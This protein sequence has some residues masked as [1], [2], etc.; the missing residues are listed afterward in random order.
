MKNAIKGITLLMGMVL[1]LTGC[2]AAATE[3]K[4]SGKIL[5]DGSSTVAPLT[6]AIIETFQ[7]K[8]SSIEITMGI[9]G[10]GGGFKKFVKGETQISNASRPMKKEEQETAKTNGIEYIELEIAKDAIAVV[11]NPAN[12]WAGELT[13]E[14]LKQIWMKDSTI[15]KWSDLDA[16]WPAE[17]IKLYGPGQDSGTFDY[18]K[19]VILGSDGEIRTDYTASEDDNVLVTGVA[20]D[21]NALGFFGYLYFEEN[22]TKLSAVA[23]NGVLPSVETVNDGTYKPLSR[24]IFIYVNKEAYNTDEAVKLFVDFYLDTIGVL[25]TDLGYPALSETEYDTEKAKLKN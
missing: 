20:G 6:G 13:S 21:K 17:Q 3:N 23:V 14:Q 1:L 25:A 4:V 5:I 9:S 12:T 19:E 10:T 15:S 18:F 7:E 16:T 8:N 11:K 22:S 24:P 2:G